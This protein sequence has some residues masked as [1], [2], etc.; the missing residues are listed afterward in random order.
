MS[1]M[2]FFAWSLSLAMLRIKW[3][4]YI[5]YVTQNSFSEYEIFKKP[6]TSWFL[7]FSLVL[8]IQL[9]Q[10]PPK[11]GT[12]KQDL[13]GLG[14]KLPPFSDSVAGLCEGAE[15]IS[16]ALFQRHLAPAFPL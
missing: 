8:G 1:G 10:V 3:N 15:S 13:W 11:K 2:T 9:I 4:S 14:P 12:C 7:E 5:W 6:F 16:P